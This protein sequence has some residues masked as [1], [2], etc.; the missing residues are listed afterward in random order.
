MPRGR[1]RRSAVEEEEDSDSD[2]TFTQSQNRS[3]NKSKVKKVPEHVNVDKYVTKTVKMLLPYAV[4]K[5]PVKRAELT[6]NA[7][8]GY[9]PVAATVLEGAKEVLNDIYQLDLVE[10][11]E[12]KVKQY[13]CVATQPALTEEECTEDQL[14]E[15]GVLF[16]I[17]AYIYMKGGEVAD[18]TLYTYLARFDILL[19]QKHHKV[20]G[21]VKHMIQDVFTKKKYLKFTKMTS[22]GSNIEK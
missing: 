17:L 22:E 5:H 3:Q 11:S 20:F 8:D 9:Q 12:S 16:V 14:S 10:L 13:I 2:F 4:L 1:P 6:N 7:M 18:L 15:M 21:D 19:D